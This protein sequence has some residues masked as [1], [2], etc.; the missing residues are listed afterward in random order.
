MRRGLK[1][2]LYPQLEVL[3]MQVGM[4][5]PMRRGLKQIKDILLGKDKSSWNGLPDEKGIETRPALVS[6]RHQ[7]R[8]GMV[9]PMRRGLKL[10][11]GGCVMS[12]TAALEWSPR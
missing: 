4:V 3:E 9:S 5:S 2:L 6:G 11:F 7:S 12:K 1:P 8:V 10:V